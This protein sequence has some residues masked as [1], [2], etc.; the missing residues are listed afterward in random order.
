MA[1]YKRCPECGAPIE[2]WDE[3]CRHRRWGIHLDDPIGGTLWEQNEI[4]PH[5]TNGRGTTPGGTPDAA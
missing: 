3:R 1:Q 2:P 4:A 5:R